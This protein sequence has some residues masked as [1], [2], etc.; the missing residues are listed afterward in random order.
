MCLSFLKASKCCNSLVKSD[1]TSTINITLFGEANV[2]KKGSNEIRG[3]KH[4]FKRTKYALMYVISMSWFSN[5]V[6][7]INKMLDDLSGLDKGP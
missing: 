4:L 2:T 1:K 5:V 7:N 6:T 3:F